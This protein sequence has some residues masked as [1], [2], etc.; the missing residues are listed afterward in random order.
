MGTYPKTQWQVY[1]LNKMGFQKKLNEHGEVIKNKESLVCK[2]YAEVEGI[3]SHD[4]FAP[5]ARVEAIKMFVA[6]ASYKKSKFY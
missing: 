4:T 1:N 5:V 2:G 6:L 3:Y